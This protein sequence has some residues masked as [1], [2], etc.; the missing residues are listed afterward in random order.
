MCWEQVFYMRQKKAV[1]NS[2]EFIKNSSFTAKE[3]IDTDI[4][5]VENATD[6]TWKSVWHE[7]KPAEE[8]AVDSTDWVITIG[9]MSNHD[10]A[11][12]VCDSDTCEVIGHIPIE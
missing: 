10:F 7:D 12:I 1:D 8:N 5:K 9:D 3:R 4:V 6:N 11:I 2:I